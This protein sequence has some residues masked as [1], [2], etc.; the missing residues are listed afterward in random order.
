[1]VEPP[2]LAHDR[3]PTVDELIQVC[4][5]LGIDF[6]LNGVGEPVLKV[7]RN[8]RAEGELLAKLLRCNPWRANVLK[9][10]GLDGT[11]PLVPHEPARPVEVL[12]PCTGLESRAVEPRQWPAGAFFWRYVGE[13][14]W[15]PIPGRTWNVETKKGRVTP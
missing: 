1:M 5:A 7:K 3:T 9:R 8:V 15:Q 6:A 10:K 2:T 11:K 4:D 14:Q 12:F 13:T